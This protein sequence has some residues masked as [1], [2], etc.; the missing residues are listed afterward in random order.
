MWNRD[1]HLERF[2]GEHR[3]VLICLF[4]ILATLAVYWQVRNQEFLN[5][6]DDTYVFE[7]RHVRAGLTLEGA[8]WSFIASTAANWHPLTWLSH[9]M[10]SQLY[11]LNPGM[12]H[13]T[14]VLFHIANALLLFIVLRRMTGDSWRSAFVAALFALHPLHVESVAWVSERKDV[15]STFFWML[16]VWSYIFYVRSPGIRRYLPV[17]LFFIL[18]LMA[19]PMIVTLPF[20]LLL[21]DYWPLGRIRFGK[22]RTEDNSRKNLHA[23]RLVWEKVPFFIVAAASSVV[24]FFVQ[25]SGGIVV[26]LDLFPLDLRIANALVSYVRYMGKMVWP[27]QLVFYY[28]HPGVL[29]M[30]QVAGSGL[31][32]IS[33]SALAIRAVR[34]YPYFVVGW[35]WFLGTLVPVI[36]VVQLGSQAMADRYT[37]VP[38]IGLFIIFAWGVPQLVERLRYKEIVLGSITTVLFLILM[39]TTRLQVRYW[40]NNIVFFEHAIDVDPN[41]FKAHVNLGNALI[42][43]DVNKA[44]RHYSEALRINSD[45][46]IAHNNLG[47]VLAEQGRMAEAVKHYSEALRLNPNSEKAHNNLGH[48]L[49]EQGKTAEAV[50]HYYDA[51]RLNPDYAEAHNNLG[52]ALVAMGDLD[53]AVGHY[54]EALRLKPDYVEAHNN[55]GLAL[56]AMGNVGKGASQ[57]CEAL[58]LNPNSTEV[59]NN[60]GLALVVLGDVSKA[61]YQYSE[62]LRLNPDS[63]EVHVNLGNALAAKGETAKALEHYSEALRLNP[64]S[65]EVHN[66][67]GA[68]L[69]YKGD[70]HDAIL[71]FKEALRIKPGYADAQD[72]LKKAL[73]AQE[74]EQRL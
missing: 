9:M 26:P 59:R 25:R 14:N 8:E 62:A 58:R 45:F 19:K 24:T 3:N 12:H 70:I 18:G 22:S 57:Y 15:L 73:A 44:I 53:K 36:G 69:V 51:L 67:L 27:Y 30:W 52:L 31:M 6:D 74:E 28:P 10:D 2:L 72:N 43:L 39:V 42:D 29:P 38:L 5:Y 16:T 55:L 60:L 61:I 23:L 13:L 33:I 11:G 68:T 4:L 63:P 41:S 65:A 56:V 47:L 40:T 48:I 64:D 17:L 35:L 54:S 34:R 7:N 71:H 37:Y 20:V 1:N 21:L 49:A 46:E 32:L 66:N 50:S